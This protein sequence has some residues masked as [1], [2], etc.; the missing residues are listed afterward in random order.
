MV[1]VPTPEQI[2]SLSCLIAD[3]RNQLAATSEFA[4]QQQ[5]QIV[6]QDRKIEDLEAQLAKKTRKRT[7]VETTEE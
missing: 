3:L 2:L 1:G 4:E 7:K 6:E 5:Q